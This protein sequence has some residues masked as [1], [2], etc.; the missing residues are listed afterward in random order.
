[1]RLRLQLASLLVAYLQAT[2]PEYANA[3]YA[4]RPSITTGMAKQQAVGASSASK[5][6]GYAHS[7]VLAGVTHVDGDGYDDL[8]N[9]RPTYAEDGDYRKPQHI[10]SSNHKQALV[11]TKNTGEFYL[12]D[13]HSDE[14]TLIFRETNRQ[15]TKFVFLDNSHLA[16]IDLAR[17]QVV[18]F[19]LVNQELRQLAELK[20]SGYP[21][22]IAW[23]QANNRLYVT[24]Q[25]SQRLYS[26]EKAAESWQDWRQFGSTDL[27]IHGGAIAVLAHRQV[28]V[29]ADAFSGDLV[30]LEQATDSQL[31]CKIIHQA[32]L[33]AHNI[34]NLQVIDQEQ[35]ILFP[36]QLLNPEIHSIESNITWGSVVSNNLRWVQTDRLLSQDG[37]EM[38]KQGRL[39]PLGEVS[40]G[41]GDP[42]SLTIG[43]GSGNSP[44][45]IAITLGGTDSVAIGNLQDR[46]LKQYSVGLHPIASLITPDNNHVYVVNEF[47]DSLTKISADSGESTEIS[48]GALRQPTLS[49]RGERLFFHSK[50]S[51]DSWMSC[52]SCHSFGHTNSQLNDSSSDGSLG[53]PK[54]VLSLLGQAETAPYGWV[55]ETPTLQHQVLNSLQFTMATDFQITRTT[56]E[57]IAE[58]VS[59]LPAP[60][61]VVKA[62]DQ[63][64]DENQQKLGRELFESLG[65]SNCHSGN[66]F[67]SPDLYDVELRDERGQSEFNPPS[68]VG[69]S[70]R[71]RS[72][73]HDGRAHSIQEV[74]A[75][76]HQLQAQLNADETRRLIQYLKSL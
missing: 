40:N 14:I 21:H 63:Q 46:E 69:V 23:D 13:L 34:A 42:T 37:L 74:L 18:I 51:H 30:V 44:N 68:L 19:E 76:G 45:L 66:L 48:L 12:L 75:S 57:A 52:H 29:V 71:E 36:F 33:F 54:R 59:S 25:W 24:G 49:E 8:A 9:Y 2:S 61:S 53:T 26:F 4:N 5:R 43:P 35:W 20:T 65:C 41:A 11:S 70:Q 67:T 31:N 7:A 64:L 22:S 3:Q 50:L 58:F 27:P 60:P 72:L 55:G 16:A 56:V 28:L 15:W 47:S 38:T 10:A 32:S 1:M 62:R 73:F 17:E 6:S 39:V